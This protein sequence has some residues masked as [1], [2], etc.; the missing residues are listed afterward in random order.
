MRGGKVLYG[1][2]AR[3]R[4]RSRSGCDTLDVCGSV[5]AG[6]PDERDR[7]DLAGAADRG[8]RGIYPAFACG[9]ADER[10]E[11][12]ADA[13][14]RRSRARRS[15]PASPSAGRHRTATASPTRAT[16]ARRV[17][18]PI[19][20][21][22]NGMQADADG[23]GVGDACDPC[24]L[25]AN[26]TTCTRVR[27]RTTR[28][29]DGVPNATDNCPNIANTDQADSDSDGKGDVCDACPNDGEPGRARAARRR[30]TRSRTGTVAVGTTV[31]RR[32][33]RWSP[34][35]GANGFFV[36]VKVGDAGYIGRG[37]LRPV[38]VHRH[39][40]A[41][42]RERGGRRARHDRRRGRRVPGRDRARHGRR[43]DADATRPE[44][45][46]A[47]I[48]ATYAE[49]ATGGT[50]AATLEG[51]LV[52]L[53]ASHGDRGR[54]DARRVHG[55]RREHATPDRRRLPLPRIRTR[56]SARRSPR[57]TGILDAAADATSKL[58]PRSADRPRRRPAGA[59]GV[60]PGDVASSRVG[61]TRRADVPDAA[62]RHAHRPGAGRRRS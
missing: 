52:A 15:T 50:R 9:A 58:E 21:M 28:D 37:L 56:P 61:A 29:G 41:A 45:P 14:G 12:H 8:R 19:R 4:R 20:P 35:K 60:R 51:V 42:A 6:L 38:R 22:D 24:P 59:R 31:A 54:R 39:R 2:D 47:P 1:D 10:A 16:T 30:S 17:F 11:L 23:D 46:P 55:D 32:R 5:E 40:L 43:R 3:R 27:I 33:T 25:D 57:V 26:T 36:Q 49:V 34:A 48:A 18:N 13:P 62:H 7:Q 53:G 44:A